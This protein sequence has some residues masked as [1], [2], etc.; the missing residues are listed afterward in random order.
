M[1]QNIV[2]GEAVQTN[3]ANSALYKNNINL[4]IKIQRELFYSFLETTVSNVI[5]LNSRYLSTPSLNCTALLLGML[6]EVARPH[7]WKEKAAEKDA[8]T[9]DN[10]ILGVLRDNS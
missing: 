4:G 7:L 9:D 8:K 6:Q 5:R 2:K 3:F 1:G 10:Y